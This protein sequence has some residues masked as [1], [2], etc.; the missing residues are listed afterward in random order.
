LFE[1]IVDSGGN[2]L[3]RKRR[4]IRLKRRDLRLKRRDFRVKKRDFRV[5]RMDLRLLNS[6]S[7]KKILMRRKEGVVFLNQ[8]LMCQ[9]L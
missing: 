7:F 3:L 6:C 1:I 5:K 9:F 2:R 8:F 4:D